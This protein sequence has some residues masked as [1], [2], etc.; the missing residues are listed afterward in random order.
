M[1][2]INSWLW[3]DVEIVD[4][5]NNAVFELCKQIKK[6][7]IIT[8]REQNK[9]RGRRGRSWIG[10]KDNLFMSLAFYLPLDKLGQTVILSGLAVLNTVKYFCPKVDIKVKWPNDVLVGGAKIS[11]ILFEKGP[12]DFWIMGIGVNIVAHPKQNQTGYT[13]TGL[14]Y[15]GANTDRLAVLKRFVEIWDTMTEDYNRCGFAKFKQAWLDNAFKLGQKIIIKQENR[16]QEGIFRGID[17]NGSLI[18]EHN[19]RNIKVLAGDVFDIK[20]ENGE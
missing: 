7:C 17:D 19:N 10:Y 4:S 9:G 14:N 5:T 20:D 2:K 6:P 18:L 1:E 3:K 15:L 12:D 13:T 11:G 8:A 16:E